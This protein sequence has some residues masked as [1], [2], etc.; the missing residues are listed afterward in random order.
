MK[1][2]I[3]SDLHLEFGSFILP[4]IADEGS[5]HLIL[6]GDI[7]LGEKHWMPVPFF[8]DITERFAQIILIAG[9]HE[10]YEGVFPDTLR[11]I[12]SIVRDFPNI[13][14]LEKETLIIGNVA[15]VGATMWTDMNKKD[16]FCVQK[17]KDGMNDFYKIK[18]LNGRTLHP[19]DVIEDHRIA[20]E[21]IFSEITRHKTS[22]K[23]VV[24][25]TH[26]LPCPLSIP[27]KFRNDPING[28]YTSDL[29]ERIFTHQ[30]DLWIH[31]HTH[32]SFDYL[33][34]NTRVICNPRGYVGYELNKDFDSRLTIDLDDSDNWNK[35]GQFD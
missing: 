5:T 24:V 11:T 8:E 14:F 26:H 1:L 34:E 18:L 27:E 22:G 21:F 6:A 3:V 28:A 9:N 19:Y 30:P 12:R 23:K 2:R 17:A 16:W 13:A 25:I 4:T 29:T 7:F 20:T 10:F 33:L 31:G 32:T 35:N 15:F